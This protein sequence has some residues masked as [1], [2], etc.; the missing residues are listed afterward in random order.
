MAFK[1]NALT[2][3]FRYRAGFRNKLIL[4]VEL[5]KCNTDMHFDDRWYT[6]WR[7]ATIEDLNTIEVKP[8]LK[9]EQ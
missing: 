4:Q 7:D 2:G 1:H 5:H 8:V 9:C 6:E 3:N